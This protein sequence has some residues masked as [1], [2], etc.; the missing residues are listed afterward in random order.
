MSNPFEKPPVFDDSIK[1]AEAEEE[2]KSSENEPEKNPIFE[3]VE[4]IKAAED[5]AEARLIL[6]QKILSGEFATEIECWNYYA[7][8]VLKKFPAVNR[9]SLFFKKVIKETYEAK[10]GVEAVFSY[11]EKNT[12]DEQ[13]RSEFL[14]RQA[15][16]GKPEGEMMTGKDFLNLVYRLKSEDDFARAYNGPKGSSQ[17]FAGFQ[18]EVAMPE[19]HG[20]RMVPVFVIKES[21]I[22]DEDRIKEINE[23]EKQHTINQ[24]IVRGREI[25]LSRRERSI[26]W[27]DKEYPKEL[28]DQ[29][30]KR[31]DKSLI[32]ENLI[33]DEI[34][35]Y[36]KGLRTYIPDDIGANKEV[37]AVLKDCIKPKFASPDEGYLK[38]Y[39]NSRVDSFNL[40]IEIKKQVGRAIKSAENGIDAFG[41]L[42]EI[43]NHDMDMAHNVLDQFPLKQWPAVVRLIKMRQGKKEKGG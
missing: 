38:K 34:L 3:A 29:I 33:K 1:A 23:H 35:A 28:L 40:G 2:K 22:S 39:L 6:E 26:H 20:I 15:F 9:Y 19:E 8:E 14:F 10:N 37:V 32:V 42:V 41:E 17:S 7:E 25:S 31:E 43:Y 5:I 4:K 36:F 21:A 27:N 12:A 13:A 16:E 24:L 18:T 30:E 11:A